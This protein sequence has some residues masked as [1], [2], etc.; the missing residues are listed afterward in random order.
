MKSLALVACIRVLA[1]SRSWDFTMAPMY[2]EG[3]SQFKDILTMYNHMSELCFKR[4]VI[5]LNDRMLSDE[6]KA[7]TDVCAEK[8]MKFNN[9]LMKV[10]VV[11]QPK[12][13]E[14][15]MAEATKDAEAAAER[16][17]QQ[18]ADPE[19]LSAQEVAREALLGAKK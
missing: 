10:F 6:E 1:L 17:R 12:A 18:G 5:N 2:D 4:C 13:T 9:R 14:R 16:L 15:R 11:E 8:A 19:T 7:C 3:L